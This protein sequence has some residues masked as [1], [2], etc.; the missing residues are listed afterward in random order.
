MSRHLGHIDIKGGR[1]HGRNVARSVARRPARRSSP[2]HQTVGRD[3]RLDSTRLSRLAIVAPQRALTQ[4]LAALLQNGL[5]ASRGQGE[6][7]LLAACD[8][9]ELKIEVTD[10]ER[11]V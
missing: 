7:R 11:H 4:T 5:D 8:S 10:V 6:V 1:T 3:R 2:R 9:G